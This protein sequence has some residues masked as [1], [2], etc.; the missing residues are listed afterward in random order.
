M[1]NQQYTIMRKFFFSMFVVLLT[2]TS[3]MAQD[4]AAALKNAKKAFDK[5]TLTQDAEALVEAAG[6]AD[7]AFM[8]DEVKADPKL[9]NITGSIFAGYY[10]YYLTNRDP[11]APADPIIGNAMVKAANAYMMAFSKSDKKGAKKASLKGLKNLQLNLSNQ[12]KVAYQAR[13]FGD[14]SKVFQ[15]VFKVHEFLGANGGETFYSDPLLLQEEKYFAALTA[16]LS[17]DYT[18]AKKFYTE[19]YEAKY[20]DAS[21][22]DGLSKIALQEK[23]NLAAEKYLAEGRDSF[24]EDKGLLFGQINLMLQEDKV[25]EL[26]T[27]LQEGI[28]ADPS[29]P[30]LYLVL[31]QTFE[32]LF[33]KN[34]EAGEDGEVNFGKAISTLEKGLS[35]VPDDAKLT[36]ALGLM[37][38][39]RGATMSQE[40]QALA[41]DLS[42]EGG[43]KYDAMKPLVDAQFAKA[44]PYFQK[45][46]MAN[47]SDQSTLQALKSMYA[48]SSEFDL[49][50]EFK[51]RLERVQAGET[52]EKSYFKEK[53]M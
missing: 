18:G 19:L 42:K 44:L 11:E 45:A 53:G 23:D 36:Y 30:S 33:N 25:E 4:G 9:L 52:I 13:D 48:R 34:I 1:K 39:N 38:F 5:F 47:P 6:L 7:Q 8:S 29:N 24:P 46:E 27:S 12:G 35:M 28:E 51:A 32:G 10:N 41:D 21:V 37:E 26:M 43:K 17:E 31:A 14:A 40:L 3:L 20:N 49:S 2:A 16:L 50:N 15:S 22:Y